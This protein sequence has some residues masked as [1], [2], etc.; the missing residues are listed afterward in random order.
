MAKPLQLIGRVYTRLTVIAQEQ[1]TASGHT[2][3]RCRCECGTEIVR[4]GRDLNKSKDGIRS[5]G[6][7]QKDRA[8]AAHKTHGMSYHPAFWVWRS[9][10]DRCRLPSHQAWKNY[11]GRGI[12]VDPRWDDFDVFWEDMGPSYLPGLSLDRIDNEKGYNKENCR[13]TTRSIQCRNKRGNVFIESPWGRVTIAEASEKSGINVTTLL[14]RV[15]KN[16]PLE[17]LFEAPYSSR[18]K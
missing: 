8:A 14:W 4:T 7:L 10:R 17:R 11:G 16:R 12:K 15:A 5:C 13:W 2:R 3:W 18:K 1:N 6:C 9:M